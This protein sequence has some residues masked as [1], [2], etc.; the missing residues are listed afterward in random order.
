MFTWKQ[1]NHLFHLIQNE[2]HKMKSVSGSNIFDTH[3][4]FRILFYSNQ[5][6]HDKENSVHFLLQLSVWF[7]KS[8]NFLK[9]IW[10]LFFK[11]IFVWNLFS[12]P[13]TMQH[14]FKLVEV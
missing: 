6:K 2:S 9:D 1:F 4:T 3:R 8:F 12:K 14:G 5:M 13:N 11:Q 10:T 7:N